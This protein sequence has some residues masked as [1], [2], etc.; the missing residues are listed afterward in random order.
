MLQTVLLHCTEKP[1]CPPHEVG[2]V[3]NHP[4]VMISLIWAIAVVA[5]V[6]I[7]QW[8]FRKKLRTSREL[9]EAERRHELRLKEM[10]FEQEKEWAHFRD[11]SASTDEALKKQ[12]EE[13]KQAISSLEA[14]LK[15]EKEEKELSDQLL[16]SYEKLFKKINLKILPDITKEK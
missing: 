9:A 3:F 6:T 4:A 10:T 5:V 13:M 16:S 2:C 12:N 7:V 8:Y 15:R 1:P 14:K 11:I